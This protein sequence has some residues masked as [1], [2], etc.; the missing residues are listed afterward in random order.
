MNNKR[1]RKN[2]FSWLKLT[3]IILLLMIISIV[4]Y[5][6]I[7]YNFIQK[8][9]QTGFDETKQYVLETTDIIHIEHV[10]RFQELDEYHIVFGQNDAGEDQ[11]LFVSISNP[12][13]EIT[14]VNEADIIHID[15]LKKQWSSHCKACKLISVKPAMID[16]TPLWELTYYDD[17][18]RFVF[19]YVSIYDGSEFEKIRLQRKFK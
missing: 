18:N 17:S 4:I 11:L 16:H 9:K 5:F 15:E 13:E 7:T 6:F 1:A 10:E 3:F 14:I 8:S 2:S 12:D 19:D